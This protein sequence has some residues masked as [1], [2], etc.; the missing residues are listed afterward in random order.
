MSIIVN[1]TARTLHIQ[2]EAFPCRVGRLGAI[3]AELGR[4]GDEKTPL[5]TYRFRF[6]LYRPDRLPGRPPT[7]LT[8]WEMLNNDGWCDD[9][10]HPAYNRLIRLPFDRSHEKLWRKDGVYDIVL[11]ISHND[12]P[13]ISGRGSAVFIHIARPDDKETLGCIAIT[14]EIMLR[15]LSVIKTGTEIQFRS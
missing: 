12:S 8:M 13:P 15:L 10:H 11:V 3:D 6:G 5:G 1:C 9:P 7:K 2:G 14:P 4:E